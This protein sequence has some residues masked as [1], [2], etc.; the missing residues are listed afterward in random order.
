MANAKLINFDEFVPI[1]CFREYLMF[2]RKRRRAYGAY[3]KERSVNKKFR[4]RHIYF[5]EN[6]RKCR[7]L[8]VLTKK[9]TLTIENFAKD[10]FIFAK[11]RE[12]EECLRC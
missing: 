3:E 2:S 4:E 5:R 8:M 6:S 9:R 12:N 10:I 11:L 1:N 7:V